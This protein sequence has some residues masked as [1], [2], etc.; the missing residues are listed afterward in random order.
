MQGI[1]PKGPPG[2]RRQAR[3]LVAV[4]VLLC[5]C[6]RPS[7]PGGVP[8]R[9]ATDVIT[10]MLDESW[11]LQVRRD[12]NHAIG[13]GALPARVPV[14]TNA[15]GQSAQPGSPYYADAV[16]R[17]AS[18]EYFPLLYSRRAVEEGAVHT[19]TLQPDS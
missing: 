19:L 10:V 11:W 12:G 2:A 8:G 5:G 4:A 15:P 16:E 7:L 13:F 1:R 6:M 14:A 3:R 9:S 17:L 18:G